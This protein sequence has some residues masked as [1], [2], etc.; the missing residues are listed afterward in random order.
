M[1]RPPPHQVVFSTETSP[2]HPSTQPH[3]LTPLPQVVF[4]TETLAAG[5]NMPARSTVVTVLSK[6][7]DRGI[8][9]LSAS[10]LLQMA[11]RAGRRWG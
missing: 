11:G 1:P 8:E 7:G 6:R 2:I 9:P 5:I 10:A 3:P 4:S